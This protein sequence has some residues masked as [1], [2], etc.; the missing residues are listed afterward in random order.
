MRSPPLLT[1]QVP[2]YIAG[3]LLPGTEHTYSVSARN[4]LGVGGLSDV[5]TAATANAVG[6]VVSRAAPAAGRLPAP[7]LR[8]SGR[9]RPLTDLVPTPMPFPL[10]ALTAHGCAIFSICGFLSTTAPE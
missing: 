9:L 8:R 5:L 1:S 4:A 3:G 2:Q 6:A 7:F 10:L